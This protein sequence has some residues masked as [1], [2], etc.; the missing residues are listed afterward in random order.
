ML[1]SVCISGFA[2]EISPDF[3]EQLQTVTKLGMHY[4]SLRSANKKGIAD[5]TVQ[6]VQEDLMPVLEKY[7][8]RVSSIG[9]PI[10]KVGVEDEEGFEKQKVQ[11]EELCKICNLLD[12]RY[13]RMFSFFIPEGKDADAYRNVVISKLKQFLE[14]AKQYDVILIMKTR[15]RFMEIRKNAARC[16]SKKLRIPTFRRRLILQ[17]SYNVERI[18]RRAG[19][20][21][22]LMLHISISRTPCQR[23]MKMLFAEPEKE[24]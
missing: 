24:K 15:K 12:C 9:S 20:C 5:Y 4:I 7:Q 18:Q 21:C 2:D 10:G 13:I 1:D 6:E 11:L 3:E 16:C 19:T 23:I 8:V 14:L 22:S 17:T